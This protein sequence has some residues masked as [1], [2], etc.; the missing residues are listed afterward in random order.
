[1]HRIL[2][3]N[4]GEILI[5]TGAQ[6]LKSSGWA[7]NPATATFAEKVACEPLANFLEWGVD[8]DGEK[9]II[10]AYAGGV[11]GGDEWEDSR[12][13]HISTDRGN[14][15]EIIYDAVDEYGAEQS[16]YS[17]LHAA[18]YDP[19]T[20]TFFWIEGHGTQRGIYYSE[21][22]G[23]TK[24]RIEVVNEQASYPTTLTVTK[25]GLVVGT[26]N[27]TNGILHLRRT[28]SWANADFEIAWLLTCPQAGLT[29]FANRGFKDPDTGIVYIGYN[30]AQNNVPLYIAASDGR[31]AGVVHEIPLAS[32]GS[33]VY[34]LVAA[35][36]KLI[37]RFIH[38]GN[39]TSK[40]LVADTGFKA[41]RDLSIQDTGGILGGYVP[42]DKRGR[43]VAAGPGSRSTADLSWAGGVNCVNTGASSVVEGVAVT[44]AAAFSIA[45]GYN[46]SI[47]V[48]FPYSSVRGIECVVGASFVCIDGY[49]AEVNATGGIAYG[50][51]AEVLV[52]HDR[53]VALG[54]G[55]QSVEADAVSVGNRKIESTSGERSLV[56][57]TLKGDRY[58]RTINHFGR[59]VQENLF[60]GTGFD[61][62]D[63][64][65]LVNWWKAA[66][67]STTHKEFD[68]SKLRADHG[69]IIKMI[70]A[71]EGTFNWLG[72]ATGSP[73]VLHHDQFNGKQAA[74]YSG[75]TQSATGL[76]T[77]SE[78]ATIFI[79]LKPMK[80]SG[81]FIVFF[82]PT[83]TRGNCWLP[84]QPIPLS[85][86]TGSLVRQR[87]G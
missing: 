82:T 81:N 2:P 30:T 77:D 29:A 70:D 42:V 31:S 64:A 58:H 86:R 22:D 65:T 28:D 61:P 68:P 46:F 24:Q 50:A 32:A 52:G 62:R 85:R 79:A 48:D 5:V 53:A 78:T 15:W 44:N 1:V 7:A 20:D 18:A 34:T 45:T 80:T 51:G 37:A 56:T 4:D 83:T 17:H 13:V 49:Q 12:Y 3:C 63:I 60:G 67:V 73:P 38:D 14:T 40:T 72:S 84:T 87:F 74:Y 8:G 76:H 36:G 43:A 11:D 39:A 26:D 35:K 10:V 25:Y 71:K 54:Q 75:S 16:A 33:R 55:S 23:A 66:E 6:L 41:I 27:I 59:S 9:F 19:L 47:G 57:R 21:D 69:D